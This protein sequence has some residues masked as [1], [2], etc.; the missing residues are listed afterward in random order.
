VGGR[1]GSGRQWWSWIHIDDVVAAVWHILR[2]NVEARASAPVQVM[3]P[4]NIVAPNPVTNAD[5]TQTLARALNR[6]AVLPI[7]AFLARLA[8]G[9]LADEGL[10]AS[11]R[12][13]PRKLLDSNF[14]F[15]FADLV[16]ALADLL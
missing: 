4:V 3:G 8:F 1:I 16:A 9:E 5:F 7:P 10:L 2:G 11:A 12:V 15:K 14:V 6:P 13:E